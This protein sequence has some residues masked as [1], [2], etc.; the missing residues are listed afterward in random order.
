MS[1]RLRKEEGQQKIELQKC[2]VVVA[3]PPL[4]GKTTLAEAL[5]DQ[6]NVVYLDIDEGWREEWGLKDKPPMIE[7][8][9]HNHQRAE[10]HLSEGRPV[11][12]GATYSWTG[13]HKILK[14][15]AERT[16]SPLRVFL[17]RAPVEEIIKRV[18]IR[19]AEG[20][21]SDVTTV[22]R[23]VELHGLYE[24]I[25]KDP[26]VWVMEIDSSQPVKD[27]VAIVME[28]LADLKSTLDQTP[29]LQN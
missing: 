4:S 10:P 14:E 24:S 21:L 19:Q 1:E 13:Y 15:L 25:N 27:I 5:L 9:E 2:I 8:Y 7:C 23:A 11:M 18:K 3:G 17:L 29:L 26:E 20:G 22:E 6:I 12:L 16:E 28:S